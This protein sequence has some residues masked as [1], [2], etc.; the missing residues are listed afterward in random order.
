MTSLSRQKEST[1]VNLQTK[2]TKR[3]LRYPL[4]ISMQWQAGHYG[5]TRM[6]LTGMKWDVQDAIIKEILA[7]KKDTSVISIIIA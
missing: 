6:L 4:M 7:W 5:E 1:K 3:Q 2:T